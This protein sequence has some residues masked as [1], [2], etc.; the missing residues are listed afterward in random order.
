[1]PRAG[2][3]ISGMVARY[4]HN[5]TRYCVPIQILRKKNAPRNIM[6]VISVKRTRHS[7]KTSV[8]SLSLS[9]NSH[10]YRYCTSAASTT[11]P[12]PPKTS[13]RQTPKPPRPH[14][15]PIIQ[16]PCYH[17]PPEMSEK[18]TPSKADEWVGPK[19]NKFDKYA[20]TESQTLS[21]IYAHD[22]C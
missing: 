7:A 10:P 22:C 21:R 9:Q 5:Q 13:K 19:A 18:P 3:D 1:M 14:T 20:T 15:S 12:P 6:D 17:T 11:F 4:Q 8:L 16:L 2:R